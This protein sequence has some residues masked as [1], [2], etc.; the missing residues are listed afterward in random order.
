MQEEVADI[1]IV[2][3]AA[4]RQ[5]IHIFLPPPGLGELDVVQILYRDNAA[6]RKQL[7][8]TPLVADKQIVGA[9]TCKQELGNL[10]INIGTVH[11]CADI[12]NEIN[13]EPF[14]HRK[15]AR[16]E[17]VLDDI[18]GRFLN[19]G[20]KRSLIAGGSDKGCEGTAGIIQIIGQV[21]PDPGTVIGVS[22]FCLGGGVCRRAVGASI[23][24]CVT[25]GCECGNSHQCR[26]QE[27]SCA[28]IGFFHNSSPI[29]L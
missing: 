22:G 23:V 25:A 16:H 14:F 4:Q 18:T 19:T 20:D 11:L 8:Q 5:L 9:V 6:A 17:R 29:L 1:I 21:V 12:K 3:I 24:G 13:A 27:G 7:C 26:K 2:R 28:E 15:I 10:S